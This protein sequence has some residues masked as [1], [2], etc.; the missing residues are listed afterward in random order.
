M[1]EDVKA[2][3]KILFKHKTYTKILFKVKNAKDR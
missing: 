2:V 3:M 1:N